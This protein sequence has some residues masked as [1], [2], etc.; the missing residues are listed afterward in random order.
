MSESEAAL[1]RTVEA[2]GKALLLLAIALLIVTSALAAVVMTL[3]AVILLLIAYT[4]AGLLYYAHRVANPAAETVA[5]PDGALSRRYAILRSTGLAIAQALCV[6]SSIL[7]LWLVTGW[8]GQVLPLAFPRLVY[9]LSCLLPALLLLARRGQTFGAL[10]LGGLITM[11]LLSVLT[12]AP[13]I[14]IPAVFA[15]VHAFSL[16]TAYRHLSRS[17]SEVSDGK[18]QA[19]LR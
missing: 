19:A 11:A 18:Q 1:S 17:P 3:T 15:A 6:L 9:G 16:L 5:L 14:M 2:A 12:Y 13:P 7:S 4:L 8:I 10:L